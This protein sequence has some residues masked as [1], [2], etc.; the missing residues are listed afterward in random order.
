MGFD[1]DQLQVL[2]RLDMLLKTVP[3]ISSFMYC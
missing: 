1:F 3:S 2:T